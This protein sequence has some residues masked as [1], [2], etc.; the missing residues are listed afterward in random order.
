MYGLVGLEK[1]KFPDECFPFDIN[2]CTEKILRPKG[3]KKLYRNNAWVNCPDANTPR[4]ERESKVCAVFNSIGESIMRAGGLGKELI[5]KWTSRFAPPVPHDGSTRR[6][7]IVL[8]NTTYVNVPRDQFDWLRVLGETGLDDGGTT[9]DEENNTQLIFGAQ[10]DRRF[11]LGLSLDDAELTLYVFNRGCVLTS[12]TFD[13]HQQPE[14]LI[15]I[16]AGFMFASREFLGFDKKMELTRVDGR[17]FTKVTINNNTYD[18]K[19]VLHTENV[20]HGRAT[21]CLRVTRDGRTYVVKSSWVDMSYRLNEHDILQKVKGISNVTQMVEYECVKLDTGI[22]DSTVVDIEQFMMSNQLTGD[23]IRQ[24]KEVDNL[25]QVRV[26][27]S[28]FGRP[29][30]MFKSIRELFGVFL[31]TVEGE[32]ESARPQTYTDNQTAIEQLHEKKILHQDISLGNVLITDEEEEGL[33]GRGLLIDFD[34]AVWLVLN[35]RPATLNRAV[36]FSVSTLI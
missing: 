7:Y 4:V 30:R 12:D 13:I 3:N 17:L 23:Q 20:L 33:E 14:R 16:L 15:R 32:L 35:G 36:I 25:Q 1:L 5:R 19:Q 24:F 18:I 10:P 26:V 34:R 8:M 27:L 6:L 2:E 31:D 21:V 22:A 9:Y 11:V 29:L 28:P